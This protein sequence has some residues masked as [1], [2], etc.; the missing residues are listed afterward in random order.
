[1]YLGIVLALLGCTCSAIAYTLQKIAHER[2][3]S[4]ATAPASV[5]G[6]SSS[7][8]WRYWQFPAGLAC[9]ICGAVLSVVASSMAAQS[10]LSPLAN[11]TQLINMVLAAT[12][13]K[14]PLLWY[15]I[16][17]LFLMSGGTVLAATFSVRVDRKYSV[18]DVASLF[19][20]PIDSAF[21]GSIG[22]CCALVLLWLHT[23][24]LAS[25]RTGRIG[26][27][28]ASVVA[29][30]SAGGGGDRSSNDLQVEGADESGASYANTHI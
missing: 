30:G 13:L 20:R 18:D 24:Q 28:I 17:S 5:S 9:L 23:A 26:G 1:M 22:C 3:R 6:A 11:F 2:S 25:N 8:F 16:I 27:G 10:T 14:E 7:P 12:I 29:V 4:S 15:D 19:S 21:F